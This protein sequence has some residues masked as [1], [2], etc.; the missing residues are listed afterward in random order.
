MAPIEVRSR[1]LPRNYLDSGIVGRLRLRHRGIAKSGWLRAAWSVPL[2]AIP[3]VLWILQTAGR[4]LWCFFFAALLL[5]PLP[6]AFG[7][8]GP[9]VGVALAGLGLV[10]GVLRLARMAPQ[11]QPSDICDGRVFPGAAVQLGARGVLFRADRGRRQS[12]ARAACLESPY[13]YFFIPHT[14]R[15]CG[16]A[17]QEARRSAASVLVRRALGRCSPASISTT[18]FPR[19]PAMELSLSGWTQGFIAALRAS[20][21]K[22]ARW[23][24]YARS[25]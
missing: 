6:F 25:S 7:N 19:R 5:P 20:S 24:M 2:V 18:S 23:E 14:G 10:C 21:M 13:M 22:P 3:L 11:A 4:W 1:E 17:S 12:D 9:H 15:K 16:C 8:S